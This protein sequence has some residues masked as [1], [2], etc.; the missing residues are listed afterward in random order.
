MKE[1]YGV[2][3]FPASRVERGSGQAFLDFFQIDKD[4]RRKGI[5][6]IEL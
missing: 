1:K 2:D 4:G 5:L 6:I 3:F